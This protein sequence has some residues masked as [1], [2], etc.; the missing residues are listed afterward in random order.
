M[1][2]TCF[3]PDAGRNILTEV[4]IAFIPL[5]KQRREGERGLSVAF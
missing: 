1:Q 5:D 3:I 2:L 4:N